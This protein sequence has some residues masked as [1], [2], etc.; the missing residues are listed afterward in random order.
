MK[1]SIKF[2]MKLNRKIK[3]KTGFTLVELLSVLVIMGVI[4]L[5]AIPSVLKLLHNDTDKKLQSLLKVTL[6]ASEI[7]IDQYKKGFIASND[8]YNFNYENLLLNNYIKEEDIHCSGTIQA[9]RKKG[10][11]FTYSAYLMCKDKK[12]NTI[13]NNVN[14]LPPGGIGIYGKFIV[15]YIVKLN[16][17]SGSKYNFNYTKENIY[18]EF[19]AYDL[20]RPG[21]TSGISKFVYSFNNRDWID[22]AVNETTG[23]GSFVLNSTYVGKIYFKAYDLHGNVSETLSYNIKID[24]IAPTGTISLSRNGGDFNSLNVKVSLSAKDNTNGSGVKQ[25]CVQESSNVNT[26]NWI[27][28]TTSKNLTLSGTLDGKPRRVYAWF[29]DAVGNIVQA[30][31]GTNDG[32]TGAG[33]T[34]YKE[35]TEVN[36]SG[37]SNCDKPCGGGI[38][39][40]TATDKYTGKIIPEKE[41]KQSCNTQ[42]CCSSTVISGYSSCNKTCGGGVQTVYKKSVYNGQACPSTTQACN[43]HPCESPDDYE[44]SKERACDKDK[45]QAIIDEPEKFKKFI[46]ESAFRNAMYDC[47]Q[48]TSSLLRKSDT[49]WA[50]LKKSSRY[51]LV[52][53]QG[54]SA[55][56][57]CYYNK[58]SSGAMRTCS[59][60]ACS[61]E[62][63]KFVSGTIYNGKVLV[64][65]A[66][67]NHY[68]SKTYDYDGFGNWDDSGR[69]WDKFG[70]SSFLFGSGNDISE[71]SGWGVCNR[72]TTGDINREDCISSSTWAE[73]YN[74]QAIFLPSLRVGLYRGVNQTYNAS[75]NDRDANFYYD[76]MVYVQIFKI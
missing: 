46:E 12:G 24:K 9:T 35:G 19:L 41:Q 22:L 53:G 54:K 7:Y 40:K 71:Y 33:Y 49:A 58:E 21:T 45:F 34:P 10:N 66:S 61:Y 28:Y 20:E 5:L 42:S 8:K 32:T 50:A 30:K 44:W 17:A 16:S 43:T 56:C 47:S 13:H 27:N 29:K 75:S 1:S 67:T 68:L 60:P 65:S 18:N 48:V 39:R 64:L 25:M 15:D 23:I 73:K 36:M 14:D 62:Y 38:K 63:E 57:T 2:K 55:S 72:T 70:W 74:R 76:G 69:T 52:S 59:K 31:S 11:N 4:L 26:C 37:W 51:Q 6:E 3:K